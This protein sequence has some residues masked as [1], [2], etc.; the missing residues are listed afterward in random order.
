MRSA[1]YNAQR[2]QRLYGMAFQPQRGCVPEPRVVVEHR[3]PGKKITSS[4]F[5]PQRGCVCRL[6][7]GRNPVGVGKYYSL[8]A[9]WGLLPVG[10]NHHCGFHTQLRLFKMGFIGEKG[11]GNIFLPIETLGST[12]FGDFCGAGSAG[13]SQ[14]RACRAAIERSGNGLFVDS[15]VARC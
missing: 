5:Q 10:I 6:P 11:A 3:Y 4:F 7:V 14:N 12:I 1:I 8:N 2:M 15:F 9:H 13:A